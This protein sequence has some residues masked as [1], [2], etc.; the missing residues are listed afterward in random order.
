MREKDEKN[1][2]LSLFF[3][4]MYLLDYPFWNLSIRV[5]SAPCASNHSTAL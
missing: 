5:T 1:V 4:F 2:F 3:W